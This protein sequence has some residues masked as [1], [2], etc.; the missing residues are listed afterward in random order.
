[1][2]DSGVGWRAPPTEADMKQSMRR[3]G[4]AGLL[5]LVAGCV[6]SL[7]PL[8]TPDTIAFDPAL[9]GAW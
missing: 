1:M 9:V 7:Q 3:L 8:Y 4:V 2:L 5:V 6:P